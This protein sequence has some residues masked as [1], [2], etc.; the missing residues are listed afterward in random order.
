MTAIATAPG[1][2]PRAASSARLSPRRV[3]AIILQNAFI[4]RR[5]PLRVMELFYWPLIEVVLWGFIASFLATRDADIPGGVGI[6]LG[7]VVLWDVMF[8][9]QQELAMTCLIDMWDRNVLNLYASPLRQSEYV[10]GGMLFSFAR[11][12][13]G[14]TVL[15]FVARAA[16]DFDLLQAGAVLVPALIALVGMGWGL[17]LFIRAAVLRFGSNAEVLA[18]SLAFLVQPVSAVFYP[19]EVLPGWLQRVAF[20][21]PASHVF[22]ALRAW[23]ADGRPL[24]GRLI[25]A[26]AIDVIYIALGGLALAGALRA[27]RRRGLLSRPGY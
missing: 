13:V 26:I 6:L 19:V 14:S 17:G 9:S 18:W 8:R 2:A 5:S 3:W 27:V 10:L 15:I 22:E 11:V 23:F 7:A 16:F 4:M 24:L 25:L 20:A 21:V 1:S 12:A